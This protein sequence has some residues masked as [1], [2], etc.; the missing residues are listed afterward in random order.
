[1]KQLKIVNLCLLP[2]VFAII[3]VS[4]CAG[5]KMAV[6]LLAKTEKNEVPA[7]NNTVTIKVGINPKINNGEELDNTV[8]ESLKLA[9]ANAN[10]FGMDSSQPY[11]IEANITIASQSTFSF[12]SFEGKLEIQYILYDESN[13]KI[14]DETVYTEAGSDQWYFSGAARHRRA[15][16]ANI[17][18]NVLEFVEILR[19]KLKK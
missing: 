11:K 4:G 16:A 10:I 3:I 1:M 12:G 15:R 17:S 14:I 7:V 5:P 2:F 9:L 18:K 6:D 19:S 8:K 13:N